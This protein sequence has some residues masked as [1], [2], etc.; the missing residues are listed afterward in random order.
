[1]FTSSIHSLTLKKHSSRVISR[2]LTQ[3]ANLAYEVYMPTPTCNS[4][5]CGYPCPEMYKE[6]GEICARNG[7]YNY[8]TFPNVCEMLTD[9]CDKNMDWVM[10]RRGECFPYWGTSEGTWDLWINKGTFPPK[11]KEKF[12]KGH[13]IIDSLEQYKHYIYD[14]HSSTN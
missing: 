7:E 5:I 6:Y 14:Y 4:P 2:V 8:K 9:N 3:A 13:T 11:L 12:E 10:T 1:M